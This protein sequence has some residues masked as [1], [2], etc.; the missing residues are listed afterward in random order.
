MMYSHGRTLECF[1]SK[2]I[3]VIVL[4]LIL[5][6]PL[7]ILKEKTNKCAGLMGEDLRIQRTTE[8]DSTS[9]TQ[10]TDKEKM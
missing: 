3:H 6:L 7:L 9:P 1:Y 2:L 8:V 4:P 5:C 10:A